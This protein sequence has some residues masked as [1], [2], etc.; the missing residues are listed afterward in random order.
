M[1]IRLISELTQNM[2]KEA[3][4][5]ASAR[6]ADLFSRPHL[7][8]VI[9]G[10][11]RSGWIGIIHLGLWPTDAGMEKR[12]IIH[13]SLEG[14]GR[15]HRNV[16]GTKIHGFFMAKHIMNAMYDEERTV[17]TPAVQGHKV[18]YNDSQNDIVTRYIYVNYEPRHLAYTTE[19]LPPEEY[20]QLLGR[21]LIK[22]MFVGMTNAPRHVR[23]NYTRDSIRKTCMIDLDQFDP[24]T[25]RWNPVDLY[26]PDSLSY[27]KMA[28]HEITFF[29]EIPIYFL[30]NHLPRDLGDLKSVH[31]RLKSAYREGALEELR[32]LKGSRDASEIF[33]LL[34]D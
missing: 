21:D 9:K 7:E 2:L 15:T 25:F 33:P 4:A 20:A 32:H 11:E 6:M 26:P 18:V 14:T 12:Y 27:S 19:G 10:Q 23:P 22:F 8:G 28:D 30:Y 24:R 31:A 3:A 17:Y 13:T 1:K 16:E 29:H 34:V 5:A